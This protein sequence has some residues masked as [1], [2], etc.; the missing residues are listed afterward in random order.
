M[1]RY[2]HPVY[3][4]GKRVLWHGA[5]RGGNG[6]QFVRTAPV[7][8][9]MAPNP[10][11]APQPAA[12]KTPQPAQPV[13]AFSIV[14]DPDDLVASRMAKDYAEVLNDKGAPGRAIV[15]T[16]S[17]TGIAKVMRSDMADFAIV[18]FDALSVGVK[19]APD[20]P[21]RAP[22]VAR[23]APE[24]IEIVAP[25]DAKSVGDLAGESVSFGDP[26]SATG[27]S[28]KLLFSRL[29]VAVNAVYEPLADGLDALSAG[30]RGAVV[31]IGGAEAHALQGF[32]D[33]GRYHVVA[34]PWSAALGQVYAPAR[35]TAADRPD[36]VAANDSVETVAEPMA[37]IALDA[38]VGSPR[39]EAL[40][41]TARVFFDGYEAFL[42]DGRDGHWRDVNLAADP[43]IPNIAWP[44]LDAAQAWL[45]ERKKT[46]DVSLDAFRASAKSAGDASGGPKAEDSDRLYEDLTRWRG[47]MQ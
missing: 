32:G 7:K 1:V 27:I 24:T 3:R 26:D 43:S 8:A 44:R 46:A 19:Y 22:L 33:H 14:A 13:K 38:P 25:K 31:V 10:A 30:K 36:L 4:N 20:W 12:D 28:A 35:V 18:T 16:T 42:S 5:W 34:I 9:A 45:D 39:A 23:L 40:G 29:G 47:L 17:P 15:G 6:R 37:L 11:P 21:Q 41:R 2:D